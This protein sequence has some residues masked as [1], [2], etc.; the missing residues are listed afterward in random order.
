MIIRSE[1]F[2]EWGVVHGVSTKNYG[3][4]SYDRDKTGKAEEN[5]RRFLARLDLNLDEISLLKLPVNNTSN[6]ALISKF[7]KKGRIILHEKSREVVDLHKFDKKSG[8]D[9]CIGFSQNT[10]LAI[11]PA[12]CAP[13]MLFE[14]NT[15][16]FAMIHAG[17]AGVKDMIVAKT[18]FCMKKWCQINPQTLISY[19]GPNIC[20]NH[21]KIEG[22]SY[23]IAGAIKGQLLLAQVLEKNIEMDTHC[24]FE[25]EHLFFSHFRA[26]K[27]EDE[28]RQI[29]IIG[30]K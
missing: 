6:V 27:K 11:L 2:K 19:V 22:Q 28:G 15:G 13:V 4:M 3:N 8:F 29:A 5:L 18:I 7:Q 14:P 20:Y 30:R 21:Y 26:V 16:Y 1:L 23:N 17:A 12:D 10:Y 25:D 9:A 24:T